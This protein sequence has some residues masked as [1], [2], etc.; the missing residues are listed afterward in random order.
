MWLLFGCVM[1]LAWRMRG[2]MLAGRVV[3]AWGDDIQALFIRLSSDTNNSIFG[4]RSGIEY[5]LLGRGSD[6]SLMY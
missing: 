4:V 5:V 1:L 3:I 6:I 2:E